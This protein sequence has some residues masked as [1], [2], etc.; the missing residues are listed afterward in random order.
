MFLRVTDSDL[1]LGPPWLGR[2]MF[3]ALFLIY[4]LVLGV[5]EAPVGR[6]LPSPGRVRWHDVGYGLL[7]LWGV[8]AALLFIAFAARVEFDISFLGS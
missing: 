6:W 5:T 7:G 3:S 8:G 2:G 4:G 1:N